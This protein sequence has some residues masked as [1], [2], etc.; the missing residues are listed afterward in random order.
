MDHPYIA[1]A[2]AWLLAAVGLL[3]AAWRAL[4]GGR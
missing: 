2:V 1:V 4:R 3:V